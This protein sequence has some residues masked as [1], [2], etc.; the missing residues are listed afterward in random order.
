MLI[1]SHCHL[2]FPDFKNNLTD[3]VERAKKSGVGLIQSI[4]TNVKETPKLIAL[5]SNFNNVFCSVG[6]HPS[7]VSD[8]ELQIEE[9]LHFCDNKKVIGIGE[10]GLDYSFQ[11]ANV[12]AQKKNFEKHIEAAQHTGLPIIIHSRD[13]E[14]D[15]AEIL[16]KHIR[17]KTFKGVLHCFT[18]S[19]WLANKCIEMGFYISASGIITFKNATKLREVFA[20][21][22][23]NR[24]L[25]ETDAPFLAPEPY[26]GKANKPEYVVEVAK[27]LAT[28]HRVDYSYIADITTNNFLNLFDKAFL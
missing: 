2:D 20:Q 22:P 10:T 3:V 24:I 7:N 12:D 9:I 16:E 15:T 28:I 14:S 4:S 19:I 25:V 27:C 23:L 5:I 6:T 26:R 21:I 18:S 8:N 11:N 13:A 1:D 17:K